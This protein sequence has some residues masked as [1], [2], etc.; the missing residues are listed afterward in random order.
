MAESPLEDPLLKGTPIVF[1]RALVTKEETKGHGAD[2]GGMKF[3]AK[4]V[5][6][7]ELTRVIETHLEQLN[8]H[9]TPG[10][11]LTRASPS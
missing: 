9:P 1:L 5:D 8:T 7:A 2:I 10:S 6:L 11:S 4:P 3:L